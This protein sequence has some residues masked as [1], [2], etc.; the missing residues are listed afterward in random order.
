[1]QVFKDKILITWIFNIQMKIKILMHKV[2]ANRDI[3]CKVISKPT[4]KKK[5]WAIN[6]YNQKL[7][8]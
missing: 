6:S 4:L 3:K 5:L 2:K 1:M 7:W 8:T